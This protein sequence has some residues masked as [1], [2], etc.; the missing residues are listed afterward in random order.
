M[1]GPIAVTGAGGGIGGRV[2]RRLSASGI[3][4]VL[5]VRHPSQAP[6]LPNA[7][8]R[9]ASYENEKAMAASLAGVETL[10][11]VSGREHANRIEHHRSA[12]RAA[13]EAGVD[14]VVYLSFLNAGPQATFTFARDHFHTEELIRA[15]G[16]EHTF[17]RDSLYADVAPH[18]VVGGTIKG[19]AGAGRVSW[20]SRDDIA[21]VALEVLTEGGHTGITYDLTGPDAITLEETASILS[22]VCGVGVVYLEETIEEAWE[23][24]AVYDA[25][26]WE[27]EGW[28]STYTAIA[29][30]EMGT[31]S[32]D[33]ARLSG[34]PA[35]TLFESLNR[36]P[37]LWR[38]LTK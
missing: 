35:A 12:V 11:L 30:G 33:V 26:A 1:P 18:L 28:I 6:N 22:T 38:H 13:V 8:V 2:A 27:V 16:M 24:R 4:P 23:S 21:D 36:D 7:P 17:L 32:D 37:D 9:L 19:P 10:M 3:D 34:H 5:I 15:S 20:V 25:P 14:R 29:A 31:V